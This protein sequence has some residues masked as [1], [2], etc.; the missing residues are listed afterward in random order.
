[1]KRRCRLRTL[2]V[3]FLCAI[4]SKITFT[5]SSPLS[6]SSSSS[7]IPCVSSP[8]VLSVP[9][10]SS[11]FLFVKPVSSPLTHSLRSFLLSFPL[12]RS[13]IIIWFVIIKIIIRCC[14]SW[15]VHTSNGI[16]IGGLP[17]PAYQVVI[18][19]VEL[20]L[21]TRKVLEAVCIRLYKPNLCQ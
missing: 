7:S 1:M 12:L 8:Q 17:Y 11:I 14:S 9:W 19:V 20:V 15:S 4:I 10:A 21:A 18:L 13:S 5:S 2:I 3:Q 6:L 16:A